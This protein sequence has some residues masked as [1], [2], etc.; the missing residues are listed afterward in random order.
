MK[1][2]PDPQVVIPPVVLVTPEL[3]KT[4]SDTKQ[5]QPKG[6]RRSRQVSAEYIDIRLPI[7][8][9]FLRLGNLEANSRRL[10]ER[11]LKYFM[12]WAELPFGEVT[13][14]LI[15]RYRD[16]LQHDRLTSKGKNLSRASVN[17]ALA[18]L[19][20]FFAW[21]NSIYPH[22][23]P[24]NPTL[25]VK[26]LKL[27]ATTP[28]HLGEAT[29]KQIWA[30]L[31]FLGDSHYRDEV[32]LHLLMHGLRSEEVLG[33]SI[34]SLNGRSAFISESKTHQGR[35]VGLSSGTLKAIDRYLEWRRTALEESLPSDA[36]LII[37]LHPAYRGHRLSYGGLYKAVGQIAQT[38][39]R[40]YLVDW[41]DREGDR[42]VQDFSLLQP[43][44]ERLRSSLNSTGKWDEDAEKMLERHWSSELRV[45][46]AELRELH[47]HQFRHT[48]A[49]MLMMKRLDP[50]H[51]QRL[52]GH[53]SAEV[54]RRYTRGVEQQAACQAFWDLEAAGESIVPTEL[55]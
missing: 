20:S 37:S 16:Y 7:V 53:E 6:Q 13:P 24:I 46:L 31:P 54:F 52:T 22:Q 25:N 9:E 33:L 41:L 49:T 23:C 32:L 15:S 4:T 2:F 14:L 3:T 36:P 26:S 1:Y 11:E 5:Q 38:S 18:S 34:A 44:I 10:Y 29:L 8:H 47:P 28:Q 17:A 12:K 30:T 21:L 55:T 43:A 45:V 39:Y 27:T 35:T 42:L 48:Y 50:A 51:I 19:K 40:L